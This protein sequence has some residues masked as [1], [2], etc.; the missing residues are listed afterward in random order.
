M[1]TL[2]A[3]LFPEHNSYDRFETVH[4]NKHPKV[5][6]CSHIQ[7]RM[8]PMSTSMVSVAFKRRQK[9]PKSQ[10]RRSKE[11]QKGWGSTHVFNRNHHAP[12]QKRPCILAQKKNIFKF[13]RP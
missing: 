5:A 3:R 7:Q 9:K 6:H 12:S 13:H 4:T 10:T 11:K 8:T 2:L 1:I